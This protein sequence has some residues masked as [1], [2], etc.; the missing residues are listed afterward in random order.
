MATQHRTRRSQRAHARPGTH[1]VAGREKPRP[2]HTRRRKPLARRRPMD[3]D[4]AQLQ[5]PER[6]DGMS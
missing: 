3:A 6:W 4:E 5:D 1:E 2:A